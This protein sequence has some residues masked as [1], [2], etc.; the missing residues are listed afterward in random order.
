M[1]KE[2]AQELTEQ[3]DKEWKSIQAL[4]VKKTPKAASDDK[5]EEKPKVG[6]YWSVNTVWFHRSVAEPDVPLCV[7][8]GRVWHDGQRARLWDEGSAV[9]ED[10]N[11]G[12]ARTGAEG[13]AAETGGVLIT[14]GSVSLITIIM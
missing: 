4:M 5:P 12:G 8:A 10:E 3:L 9:G 6:P 7:P 13:E 14:Q 11:P 2:E 1:Q